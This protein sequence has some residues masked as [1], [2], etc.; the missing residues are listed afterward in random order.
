MGFFFSSF[1]RTL[2]GRS[3]GKCAELE[4]SEAA[5][6]ANRVGRRGEVESVEEGRIWRPEFRAGHGD[7]ELRAGD[8]VALGNRGCSVEDG[9]G[10]A[11]GLLALKWA[12]FGYNIGSQVGPDLDTMSDHKPQIR[13]CS[14]AK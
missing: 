2:V 1:S 12:R 10:E 4:G 3:A 6:A 8:A 5:V 13:L 7:L 14:G 9:D 11:V